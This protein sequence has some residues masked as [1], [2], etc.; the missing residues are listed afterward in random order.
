MGQLGFQDD[1]QVINAAFITELKG[2]HIKKGKMLTSATVT[3][4]LNEN[5]PTCVSS[6]SWIANGRA[7]G[8]NLRR[9]RS[10]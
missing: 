9:N 3:F 8:M 6:S 10:S 1:K 7:D 4:P 2:V 5:L